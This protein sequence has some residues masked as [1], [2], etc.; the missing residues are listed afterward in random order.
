MVGSPSQSG[1]IG[2]VEADRSA[3]G[4]GP[5]R[6]RDGNATVKPVRFGGSIR[7]R[8]GLLG[9][10]RHLA[11]S[12]A[13]KESVDVSTAATLLSRFECAFDASGNPLPEEERTTAAGAATPASSETATRGL[14]GLARLI[15]LKHPGRKA[16]ARQPG[17][18]AKRT[19]R[20]KTSAR[21][22]TSSSFR[23][24]S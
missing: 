19:G 12:V 16:A 17:T 20:L 23:F 4:D 11:M 18:I 22:V 5:L 1:V 2:E 14:G 3:S 8:R 13:G 9:T 21:I 24:T 6:D 15:G 7:P 10:M